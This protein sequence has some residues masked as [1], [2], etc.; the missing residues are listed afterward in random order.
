M[1]FIIV[2]VL[3]INLLMLVDMLIYNSIFSLV[4]SNSEGIVVN[5]FEKSLLG[6]T[7][8]KT[9]CFGLLVKLP[10]D[11][12]Q[13]RFVLLERRRTFINK[14]SELPGRHNGQFYHAKWPAVYCHCSMTSFYFL[15]LILFLVRRIWFAIKKFTSSVT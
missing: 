7:L 11:H 3:I 13:I 9:I 5:T 8:I 4:V 2:Y 12:H 6:W 15:V 1:F 10:R 14:A